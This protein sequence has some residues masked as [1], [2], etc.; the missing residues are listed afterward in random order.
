MIT[1]ASLESEWLGNLRRKARR[2]ARELTGSMLLEMREGPDEA[3]FTTL[4]LSPYRFLKRYTLLRYH[5]PLLAFAWQQAVL[6]T[7]PGKAALLFRLLDQ[8][9]PGG[10]REVARWR[11]D[12]TFFHTIT[13]QFEEVGFMS[14]ALHV[15]QRVHG[16][17]ERRPDNLVWAVG[18]S[19]WLDERYQR[20][21]DPLGQTEIGTG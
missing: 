12:L 5:A 10:R 6:A 8:G 18:L 3:F 14:V 19:L 17:V 9:M 7:H 20:F 2:T 1:P 4:E 11:N 15:V 13:D 21:L 16:E